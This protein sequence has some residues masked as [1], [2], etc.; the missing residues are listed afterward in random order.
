MKKDKV[1][2]RLM[3]FCYKHMVKPILF[4]MKPDTAHDAM[5]EFCKI[6][7]HT[8]G[9]LRLLDWMV[10]TE[11]PSLERNLMGLHFK[12]PIGLSAGLDKDGDLSRCLDAAGFGFG[13]FG[14]LTAEPCRGNERP[15]FH[16]LP[17]YESLLIHAG[18]PNRGVDEVL[19]K[20]DRA[21]S[22]LRNGMITFGSIGFTNRKFV[23]TDDTPNVDAMIE[24]YAY[25]FRKMLDSSS[26]VIEVNVSCPNL[27]MGQP[28]ADEKNVDLLFSELD[29]INV[30]HDKPVMVKL[31][32]VIDPKSLDDTLE[33]LSR[34]HVDGVSVCNLR[35][36]RTGYEV[37]D[38][39]LGSMSGTPCREDA[40][41]AIK[42]IREHYG[43]R[44]VINGIGGTMDVDSAREKLDAG[45]DLLGCITVFM[46]R[47]PQMVSTLKNGLVDCNRS[48]KKE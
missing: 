18:L 30:V 24:D 3:A 12:N 22:R 27:S 29:E 38:D 46:F 15:W 47:G 17:E 6:S 16:R 42:F 25:S 4:H 21:H 43:S 13:S 9:V 39:W 19:E 41:N 31:R 5:I 36:D 10:N 44:F 45:A 20:T 33:V 26:D 35:E 34:H 14:S 2:V 32:S 28:F 1:G 23:N 37:P 48:V 8:P 7:T 40:V 11:D